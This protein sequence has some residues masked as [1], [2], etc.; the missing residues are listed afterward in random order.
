MDFTA[1]EMIVSEGDPGDIFYI[2]KE[3]TVSCSQGDKELRQMDK[4]EFFGEQALLYNTQRTATVTAVAFVTVLSL[5]REHLNVVLGDSLPKILYRNS[6][7][8][9]LEKIPALLDLTKSQIDNIA[10]RMQVYEY[11]T[12]DYV[13]S[14]GSPIGGSLWVV[15]NGVLV[16]SERHYEYRTYDFIGSE[17]LQGDLQGSYDEDYIAQ[18]PSCVSKIN[19]TELDCCL[20]GDLSNV[21]SKNELVGVLRSVG[22]FKCLAKQKLEQ[23]SQVLLCKSYEESSVIFNEKEPG[24]SFYIVKEGKVDISKK[25]TWIRSIGKNDYFGERAILLNEARTAT[26]TASEGTVCWILNRSDFLRLVEGAT[27]AQLVQRMELQDDSVQISDLELISQLGKGMFGN[28]YLTIHKETRVKY[29]LKAVARAKIH[30]Y[31]IYECLSLERSILL[32]LDHPFIVKL[33]KTLKDDQRVYFLMEYVRGM[34]LFDVIRTLDV[35]SDRDSK[36]YA[37]SLILIL[38]HLHER[39][40]IYRDLKPENIMVD[41]DGYLKLIDFGA[42]KMVSDRA[43][44]ITGTPHYMS[45]EVIMGKGYSTCVDLWAFGVILFE[46][47]CGGVPFGEDEEDPYYIYEKVLEHNIVYPWEMQLDSNVK[48]LIEQLLSVN[49]VLRG[50]CLT[51]KEHPWF[52]GTNWDSL[53]SKESKAPYNPTLEKNLTNLDMNLTLEEVIFTEEQLDLFEIPCAEGR[54]EV[55]GW[56]EDF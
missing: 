36:F 34:D 49:P 38:E 1:G 14:K 17:T 45:P 40:I 23:L 3:G 56:D 8:M 16:T 28:V 18:A 51:V 44:T 32:Q 53:L 10:E 4:G 35:L 26:V 22:L 13:I 11:S 15:L 12:G 41:Q 5:G 19:K 29:A 30:G 7:R 6:Q 50:N 46:F 31:G 55:T 27:R 20:G 33:V 42:A 37:A 25:G 54:L 2:I 43:Y 47:L 39:N 48:L 52:A 21:S 9:T 24:D